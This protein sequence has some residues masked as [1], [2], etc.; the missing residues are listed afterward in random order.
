[1]TTEDSLNAVLMALPLQ[2][3]WQYKKPIRQW[4]ESGAGNDDE[5]ELGGLLLHAVA[6]VLRPDERVP[7]IP[8]IQGVAKTVDDFAEEEVISLLAS[9]DDWPL[10]VQARVRDV[11]WCRRRN[12]PAAQAAVQDYVALGKAFSVEPKLGIHALSMLRR[13]LAIAA[14]MGADFAR[15]DHPFRDHLITGHA[16]T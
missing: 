16:G 10:P 6:L 13:A 7:L 9:V 5:R 3:C 2:D 12:V 1:M 15:L 4:L 14:R 11:A 8:A